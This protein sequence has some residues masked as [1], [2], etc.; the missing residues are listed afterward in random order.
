MKTATFN[1]RKY[2]VTV[3]K[4]PDGECSQ[5]NPERELN[6]FADMGTRNGLITALHECLHASRWSETEEVVERVSR[7]I[8]R[9]LWNIGY[10]IKS[11]GRK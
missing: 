5:Y 4:A 6:I 3:D 9:F 10:R 1:G 7:D 8:G 11:N 2:L